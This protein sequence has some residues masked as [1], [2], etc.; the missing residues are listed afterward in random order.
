MISVLRQTISGRSASYMLEC[1]GQ[2]CT[3]AQGDFSLIKPGIELA[4]EQ[5]CRMKIVPNL[6]A[7][8]QKAMRTGTHRIVLC[9]IVDAAGMQIGTIEKIR[10][11]TLFSAYFYTQLTLY[12]RVLRIY[13]VGLGKEGICCPIYEE[14]TQLSQVEKN[15]RP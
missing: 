2:T 12:D 8:F 5:G 9:D 14:E 10:V 1:D 11:G 15:G 7:S 13:E 3:T 4:R 6:G